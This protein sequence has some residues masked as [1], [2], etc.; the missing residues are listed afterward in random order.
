MT[1]QETITNVRPPAA[2]FDPTPT[3]PTPGHAP[4][5]VV[6][7]VAA[8]ALGVGHAA[9]SVYWAM[10]GT[11]L[12]STIGGEIERL[13]RERRPSVVAALLGIAVAKTVVALAAPIVVIQPRWMPRWATGRTPRIL[14]WIA[15]VF[16]A[17]YGT[18]LTLGAVLAV[19][20]AVDAGADA[21]RGALAW[22]AY[23]WDPW[24]ALWGAAFI[25]GLWLTRAVAAITEP[26][27]KA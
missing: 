18:V 2:G 24:F 3:V 6:A 9:V 21:D 12:V 16:L 15:A 8:A 23:F 13:G 7:A 19:S 26:T 11:A 22:H 20:G 4:I 10:G 14:S 17:V 27:R 1:R 25:V 5:A